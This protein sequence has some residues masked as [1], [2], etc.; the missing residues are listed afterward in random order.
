MPPS[1][2]SKRPCVR[3]CAPVKA[4]FSWPKSSLDQLPRNGGHVERH[5]RAL[6][7]LAVIVQHA[8]DQLLAGAALARDHDGQ[9]GLREPRQHAVDLLHGR[10]AADERQP[11]PRSP[12]PAAPSDGRAARAR[13]SSHRHELA[14]VEGLRQVLVG[15]LLGRGQRRHQRVLCAHHDDRQVGRS[16]LMR[17]ISSK[18]FS[19]GITTSV[20]TT[21]PSPCDTQRQRV[22][23]LPVARGRS[24]RAQAPGSAPCGSRCR[25]R[26]SGSYRA[27]A[28]LGGR[29]VG[30]R[31]RSAIGSRTRNTVFF[32]SDSH[33]MTPPWSPMILAT[34]ASPRPV[35][36]AWW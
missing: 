22:A 17:G 9:I 13:A 12:A 34:R 20:M 27:M 10:R 1:A 4:P 6:A 5:E 32:G 8:G 23:A 26:R 19:S 33:S 31:G 24:R 30:D 36:P 21:S 2:C 16:R 29:G 11:R 18:A 3:A 14:Q 25:R 28:Y 15:A 35:P 7:A